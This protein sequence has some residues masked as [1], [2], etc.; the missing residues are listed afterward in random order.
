MSKSLRLHEKY[1]AA[2][3]MPICFLCGESKGEVVLLGAAWRSQLRPPPQHMCIDYEPCVNCQSMMEQGVMLVKV[4]DGS[5]EKNPDRMGAII[6]VKDEFVK[7]CF[8]EEVADDLI[9]NRAAFIPEEA[10]RQLGLEEFE[11][12]NMQT[13]QEEEDETS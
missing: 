1:G 2:P 5:N 7:D 8:I 12:K 3:T 11:V 4:R 9:E 13:E 6:V 10:W